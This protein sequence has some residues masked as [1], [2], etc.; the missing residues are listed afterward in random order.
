MARVPP[1][2]KAI[3]ELMIVVVLGV[4]GEEPSHWKIPPPKADVLS[5][6][7]ESM[8]VRCP[9]PTVESPKFWIPPESP[10]PFENV[11][12]LFQTREW[13]TVKVPPSF[14]IPPPEPAV[15]EPSSMRSWL[16][17]R[18]PWF[19]TSPPK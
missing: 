18:I 7:V 11:L 17:V 10:P 12:V 15:V 13:V 2:L 4:G 8:T 9:G 3:V 5:A 16:R 1:S 14:E 6:I 19:R